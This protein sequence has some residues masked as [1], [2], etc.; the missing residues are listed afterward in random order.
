M[1]HELRSTNTATDTIKTVHIHQ[2]KILVLVE[3]VVERLIHCPVVQELP[4]NS[5]AKL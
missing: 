3:R 1:L 5:R 4:E 2:R